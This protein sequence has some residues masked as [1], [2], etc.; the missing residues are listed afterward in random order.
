MP[1]EV[2]AS[3]CPALWG[4]CREEG[5]PC[6]PVP[7][8]SFQPAA[9][10]LRGCRGFVRSLPKRGGAWTGSGRHGGPSAISAARVCVWRRSPGARSGSRGERGWGL[11]DRGAVEAAREERGWRPL[12]ALTLRAVIM[13]SPHKSTSRGKDRGSGA[14]AGISAGAALA[15]LS[16][17]PTRGTDPAPRD[18]PAAV[19]SPGA[20]RGAGPA[21][22]VRARPGRAGCRGS[23]LPRER[24]GRG[25]G[26]RAL[27]FPAAN[28]GLC[29]NRARRPNP[30]LSGFVM[31]AAPAQARSAGS[32][33]N[34]RAL[35]PALLASERASERAGGEEAPE[36]KRKSLQLVCTSVSSWHG[37]ALLLT[38]RRAWLGSPSRQPCPWTQLP[39]RAGF[40]T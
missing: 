3:S 34:A 38:H 22:G 19:P 21:T 36:V 14:S 31:Q 37:P 40:A 33:G 23:G 16:R 6:S 2:G 9:A 18:P 13:L 11:G 24:Q 5:T 27:L 20:E 32:H 39:R 8:Q 17:F 7:E 35:S 15:L 29:G 4:G 30:P 28:G 10:P 26:P 12:C 25:S 1:Q